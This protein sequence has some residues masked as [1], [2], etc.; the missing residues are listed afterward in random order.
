MEQAIISESLLFITFHRFPLMHYVCNYSSNGPYFPPTQGCYQASSLKEIL[1]HTRLCMEDGDYQIGIFNGEGECKGMWVDE[2]E[3]I[4][5]DGEFAAAPASYKLYRP[6]TMS[7]E[8]WRLHL[9]KFKK[10]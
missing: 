6:S 9:S 5:V 3:P 10:P 2:S 8:M 1:F 4:V 7:Q